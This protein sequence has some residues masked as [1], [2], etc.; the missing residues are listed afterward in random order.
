MD[1]IEI[2][3]KRLDELMERQRVSGL[4]EELVDVLASALVELSRG[5]VNGDEGAK[6]KFIEDTDK[7]FPEENKE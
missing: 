3:D 1:K 6:D 5:L 4:S 2:I 7:Y